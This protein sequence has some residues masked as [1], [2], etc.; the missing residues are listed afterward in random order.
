MLSSDIVRWDAI[1]LVSSGVMWIGSNVVAFS[2]ADPQGPCFHSHSAASA[3]LEERRLKAAAMP[4]L[5]RSM[6]GRLRTS[7]R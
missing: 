6:P 4:R 5:R 7:A 1:S 2:V 3:A